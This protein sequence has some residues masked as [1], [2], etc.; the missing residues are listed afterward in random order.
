MYLVDTLYV[1]AVEMVG[2]I[3][4]RLD[5]HKLVSLDAAQRNLVYSAGTYG[6]SP[7]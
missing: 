1:W 7:S 5:S 3:H 4:R 2:E 6:T